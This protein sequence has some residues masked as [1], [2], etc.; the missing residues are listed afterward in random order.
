MKT[1]LPWVLVAALLAGIY[2]LYADN[3]KKDA[4]IA[5]LSQDSQQLAA[6][7]TENDELLK[8]IPMQTEELTRLRKEHDEL[9]RLRSDVQKARDQN[10]Q[11]TSQLSS[12]QAQQA[13]D[14]QARD[15]AAQQAAQQQAAQ[16][17]AQAEQVNVQAKIAQ[18]QANACVN[19]LRQ[20]DAAKQQWALE[21]KKTADAV[22]NPEDLTPYL[23]NPGQIMCPGGGVYNI[24][25]VGVL[26]TC[27]VPGHSLAQAK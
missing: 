7:K 6:L 24:N 11:L 27:N 16:A 15:Q 23:Q 10:K 12:A 4:E 21:N 26:P 20:I 3:K 25:A 13:R 2:F 19:F 8:K 14:Q 9:I 17:V 22:P 1:A 18:V 5:R